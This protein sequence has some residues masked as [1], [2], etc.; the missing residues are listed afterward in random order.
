MINALQKS[1]KKMTPAAHAGRWKLNYGRAGK[2]AHR[3]GAG[4]S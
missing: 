3:A 1:W 4:L 2:V